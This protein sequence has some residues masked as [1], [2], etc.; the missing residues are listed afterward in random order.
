ML[1]CTDLTQELV[2]MQQTLQLNEAQIKASQHIEGPALVL[3][4]AGCGKTQVVTSRIAR[5]IEIG[6][7]ASEIVA[8]TFT[9]K[10]AGEMQSR[11]RAMADQYVL[12]CTFHSLCARILRESIHHLGFASDFA[13]YDQSDS[14]NLLKTCLRAM[15]IDLEKSLVRSYK[16]AISNAKNELLSPEQVAQTAYRNDLSLSGV[17]AMYQKHLKEYNALDFDDL[18]YLTVE[19]FTE[20]PEVKEIYQNRWSFFLIDEYQDTNKAQYVLTKLLVE[21]SNNL[22]VVGDPDLSI[23]SFRGAN[24]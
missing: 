17:Y 14:E 6:V 9:N 18:L 11:V 4:G 21:K 7:P 8:V 13:I 16:T 20:H 2:T 23:Y 10:A 3:A 22:F 15:N 12:A 1:G 19:L 5:L 24:V